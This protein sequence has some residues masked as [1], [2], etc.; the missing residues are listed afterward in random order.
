MPGC[1]SLLF[2]LVV[3]GLAMWLLMKETWLEVSAF[4]GVAGFTCER[5]YT[6]ESEDQGRTGGGDDPDLLINRVGE[7]WISL[8]KEEG[9]GDVWCAS[10]LNLARKRKGQVE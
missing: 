10:K 1:V 3:A 7:G 9:E 8:V 5:L 2:C 4:L 6:E